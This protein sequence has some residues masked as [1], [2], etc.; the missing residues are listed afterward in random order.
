MPSTPC[1]ALFPGATCLSVCCQPHV[2]PHKSPLGFLLDDVIIG[3][4]V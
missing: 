3:D 2:A 4:E 1:L